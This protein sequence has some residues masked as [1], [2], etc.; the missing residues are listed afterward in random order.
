MVNYI[1]IVDLINFNEIDNNCDD[2]TIEKYDN[3][4]I[5]IDEVDLISSTLDLN[6]AHLD[7]KELNMFI[8]PK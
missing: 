7:T 4:L 1:L 5:G 2:K 3:I 6:F 8:I